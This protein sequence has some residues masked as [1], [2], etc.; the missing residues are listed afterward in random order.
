MM[1]LAADHETTASLVQW[2]LH[3]L[4]PHPQY[5]ALLRNEI[6]ATFPARA[7]DLRRP[8][9]E[10]RDHEERAFGHRVPVEHA[11]R[12]VSDTGG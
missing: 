11:P 3:L 12:T 9:L 4:A 5:Q 7:H 10:W 1:F 8:R 6:R 2:A